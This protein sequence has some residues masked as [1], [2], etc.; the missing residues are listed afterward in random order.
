V[1]GDAGHLLDRVL[2]KNRI[3]EK[4]NGL[5]GGEAQGIADQKS[6]LLPIRGTYKKWH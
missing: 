1:R 3:I 5:G 4:I 6:L 2:G